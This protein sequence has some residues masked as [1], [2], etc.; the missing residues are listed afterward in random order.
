[1][2]RPMLWIK[3]QQ[4]YSFLLILGLGPFIVIGGTAS[5]IVYFAYRLN[6]VFSAKSSSQK[7]SRRRF[8][9][10]ATTT[11]DEVKAKGIL[12]PDLLRI[13]FNPGRIFDASFIVTFP[14]RKP[15]V[16]QTNIDGIFYTEVTPFFL[17]YNIKSKYWKIAAYLLYYP[18]YLAYVAHMIHR[19]GIDLIRAHGPGIQGITSILL[20]RMTG[21]P[22]VYFSAANWDFIAAL[23][24]EQNVVG[25][26]SRHLRQA[27]ERFI[28]RNTTWGLAGARYKIPYYERYGM[29]RKRILPWLADVVVETYSPDYK[30]QEALTAKF[31]LTDRILLVL[32]ARLHPEKCID[33]V[34][35]SVRQ[36]A[37]VYSEALL[38]VCGEGPLRGHLEKLIEDLKLQD[39]VL[40][41]GFQSNIDVL[42]LMDMAKVVILPLS[43]S[44]AIE[45]A[46]LGAT[47]VAYDWHVLREWM[48]HEKTAL[49]VPPKDV[50]ALSEAILRF[51]NDQ[52]L[53]DACGKRL[54]EWFIKEYG[55]NAVEQTMRDSLLRAMESPQ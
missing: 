24:G 49:L 28:C 19:E 20:Q 5:I 39:N 35:H 55:N 3:K 8:L 38:L 6:R 14:G 26:P 32:V 34:I 42:T 52:A 33:E 44:A 31:N 18:I 50:K 40:L 11:F 7:N 41:L 37:D 25:I 43:G 45:A 4:V 46:S 2:F 17:P 15:I 51:L 22:C 30:R 21:R 23:T 10:M 1:M 47:V 13:L 9:S 16:R 53:A 27:A 48:V 36:V 12:G 29:S 54:R